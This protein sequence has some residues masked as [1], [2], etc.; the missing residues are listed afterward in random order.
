M[1]LAQKLTL[2]GVALVCIVLIVAFSP[3]P[4]E[5]AGNRRGDGAPLAVVDRNLSNAAAAAGGAEPKAAA[6]DNTS[7][8]VPSPLA[9]PAPGSA[10]V[11]APGTPP[12]PPSGYDALLARIKEVDEVRA[13]AA[14]PPPANDVPPVT[15]A[16]P[17][18]APAPIATDPPSPTIA[19]AA[20]AT[21]PSPSTPA[22]DRGSSAAP[23]ATAT[24]DP[25]GAA[26]PSLTLSPPPDA[27]KAPAGDKQADRGEPGKPSDDIL[28]QVAD[29]PLADDPPATP[30][31]AKV[32][33]V[34]ATTTE[35]AKAEQPDKPI[36]PAAANAIVTK[37]TTAAANT[38]TDLA[39][40][41]RPAPAAPL[42]PL[43]AT[44]IK[45]GDA[46]A[47]TIAPLKKID[48]P[49]AQGAVAGRS[50]KVQPGDTFS[51]IAKAAY[52]AEKH[53]M[54]IVDANPGLDP[55]KLRAGM[56]VKLPE[57]PTDK[58]TAADPAKPTPAAKPIDPV[59]AKADA[60]A[61][62]KPID[63]KL[64]SFKETTHEVKAGDNLYAISKKY[65]NTIEHWRHIYLTNRDAI[66]GDPAR[67]Q[68]GAKLK[69]TAPKD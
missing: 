43:A 21:G 20:P 58:P 7:P 27:A 42:P 10:P 51:S 64:A 1:T 8:S 60:K 30:D 4:P 11:I 26:V 39:P 56:T 65:F 18:T 41:G 38:T 22:V 2:A 45:P 19:Q 52:G 35:P 25:S 12:T 50:Y 53:W 23:S 48:A 16:P 57:L 5:K 47:T 34:K 17:L 15:P 66:G 36:A 69:I 14:A 68:S 37:P 6:I 55:K 31:D 13:A 54:D 9:A 40:P 46:A 59:P 29:L 61:A 24:G 3:A 63:A 67:L 32:G 33:A 62:A 28:N 49:A 44:V